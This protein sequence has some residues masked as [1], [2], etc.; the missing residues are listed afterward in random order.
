MRV[1]YHCE[2]C[3]REVGEIDLPAEDIDRLGFGILSPEERL[4]LV[5]PDE[6]GDGLRVAVICDDCLYG[7]GFGFS[8]REVH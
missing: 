4:E 2:R 6:G 5:Q 1:R 8:G 3:G 7:A